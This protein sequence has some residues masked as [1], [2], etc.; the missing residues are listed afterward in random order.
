MPIAVE[1][2]PLATV[3]DPVAVESLP[4]ALDPFPNSM[5]VA[6]IVTMSAP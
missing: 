5:W 4:L 2:S 1:A 6:R 3:P